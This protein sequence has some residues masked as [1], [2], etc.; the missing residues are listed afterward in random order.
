MAILAPAWAYDS[1]TANPIPAEDPVIDATFPLNENNLKTLEDISGIC[2][3]RLSNFG[4]IMLLID[5]DVLNKILYFNEHPKKYEIKNSYWRN[6]WIIYIQEYYTLHVFD[7]QWKS[8]LKNSDLFRSR[9]GIVGS[10][11]LRGVNA[12]FWSW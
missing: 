2:V 5:S 3:G 4:S 10:V 6:H 9:D 7:L 12:I 1:A 11:S 8:A